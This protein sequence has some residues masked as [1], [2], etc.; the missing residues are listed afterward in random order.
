MNDWYDHLQKRMG[1]MYHTVSCS[2]TFDVPNK[3]LTFPLYN[4]SGQMKGYQTYSYLKE[5]KE[6]YFTWSSTQSMYGLEF[7]D[8]SLG[9]LYI[10]EGVFN[11]ISL[12][13]F[14]NSVAVLCNNPKN[15]K[16]QL[17]LLPFKTVAVCDNDS[18]GLKLAKYTDDYIVMPKDLDTNEYFQKYGLDSL[19]EY[20]GYKGR[21]RTCLPNYK[22]V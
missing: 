18:A 11:A 9:T 14:S 13:H 3:A 17:S 19:A 4:L 21:V 10:S 12:L 20:V 8:Y 5:K 7:L 15:L 2:L 22:L 16:E 1:P 6:K